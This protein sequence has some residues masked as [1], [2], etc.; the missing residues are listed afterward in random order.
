M[1]KLFTKLTNQLGI[2]EEQAKGG[3]GLVF[4]LA[5]DKLEDSEFQEVTKVFPQ[6]ESLI[7]EAPNQENSL[8]GALGGI[9]SSFGG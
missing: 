7:T 3:V 2:T 8:M 4:K 6:I 5:K 1:N 9:A